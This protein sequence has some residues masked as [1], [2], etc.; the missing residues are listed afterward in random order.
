MLPAPHQVATRSG[1][2][3][4][5][6]SAAVLSVV[7]VAGTRVRQTR[8]RTL[9]EGRDLVVL[10]AARDLA[11]ALAIVAEQRPQAVLF[12][13]APDAGGLDV[14]EGLMARCPLPIVLTGAAAAAPS[15]ALARGAV[16]VVPTTGGARPGRVRPRPGPAPAGRE[17]GPR[18]HPPPGPAARAAG[19]R[20]T[21]TPDGPAPCRPA[22]TRL[23]LPVRRRAGCRG[24]SP[25]SPS[26]PPPAA[27]RRWPRSSPPCPPTCPPPWWSCST[28]PTASSSSLASWLDGCHDR[29]GP[30]SPRT[31]TGCVPGQSLLARATRTSSRA[32]AC[33]SPD[34]R[35]APGSSTSPRSTPRSLGRRGLPRPRRRCAAHRDGPRR[36][37]RAARDADPAR[38]TIGQDEPQQRGVGDAGRGRGT[39]RGRVEWAAARSPP[40]S[41]RPSPG[42]WWSAMTRVDPADPPAADLADAEYVAL[43]GYLAREAGLVFDE[44]RRAALAAIVGR[45]PRGDGRG[46]PRGV[47]RADPH[48]GL[49]TSASTCSTTSRS[50]RPTSSGTRRRWRRC[51]AGCCPS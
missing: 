31:A 34:A 26:G 45:P 42:S 49:P 4:P 38:C 27:R 29:D 39:R 41:P 16:D 37:R 44:S 23:R 5:R 36:R 22:P 28:W 10:G 13:L 20:R 14:I 50:R 30:V 32:R 1:G 46:R 6:A 25:S 40:A 8:L 18:H 47:P 7:V 43:A 17:P 15:A 19:S 21:A 48:R 3:R 24:G 51:A 35:P 9:L 11:A 2:G 12:D 33:A